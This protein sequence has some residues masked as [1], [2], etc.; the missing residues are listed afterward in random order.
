VRQAIRVSPIV[1]NW[2]EMNGMP[3]TKNLGKTRKQICDT[4][5]QKTEENPC[6]K[7]IIFYG[8]DKH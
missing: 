4:L 3:L 1:M 6:N 5:K 2:S 7:D 8:R